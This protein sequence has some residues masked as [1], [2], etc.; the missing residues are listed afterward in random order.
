MSME[1]HLPFRD[2][3]DAGQLLVGE[4]DVLRDA[5]GLVVLA[6]P[7]GGVPV[8]HEIATALH[9]PL[10]VFIVRKIGLPHNPEYAIGAIASG[11]VQ[12]LDTL[13]SGPIT[14]TALQAVLAH[15]TDELA[16]REQAYR[17]QRPPYQLQGQTVLLVD[18]GIATGATM[19]A[20]V[21][22]VRAQ[23]PRLLAVAA[24]VVSREA[25]QRLRPLVDLLVC[26]VVPAYFDAVSRWYRYF[27]QCS[28]EEVQTLLGNP[29]PA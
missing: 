22:A 13:P 25:A 20:A 6:L 27:P 24:P 8:A 4:L 19:E 3:R 12:V 15:E 26:G 1:D 18:D 28:D 7:R 23:Q 14:R 21:R 9:A 17:G 5:P 16:R 2:R 29:T 11:G 10:D